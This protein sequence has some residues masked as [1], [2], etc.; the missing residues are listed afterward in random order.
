MSEIDNRRSRGQHDKSQPRSRK[1]FVTMR[2]GF[3][4]EVRGTACE[5]TG[6]GIEPQRWH[7]WRGS[8]VRAALDVAEQL[9]RL[10]R[11]C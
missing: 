8:P 2:G 5:V 6:P 9:S 1:A 4:V 11:V 3:K 7:C 10:R